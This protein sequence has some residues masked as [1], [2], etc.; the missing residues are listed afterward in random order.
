MTKEEAFNILLANAI[1]ITPNWGCPDCP[2][3]S[4]KAESSDSSYYCFDENKLSIA[5]KTIKG[6]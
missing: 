4:R 3:Y 1:C 5:I 2:L 6:G